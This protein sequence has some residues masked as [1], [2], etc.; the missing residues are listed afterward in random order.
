[1]GAFLYRLELEDG[2][3]ADPPTLRTAV[4]TWRRGDTIPLGGKTLRATAV[5]QGNDPAH[6]VLPAV[7]RVASLLKRWLL[8]THH[9]GIGS[10]HVEAY[11]D[12]S[13]SASTGGSRTR[14]ACS[15]TGCSR[16]P[17]S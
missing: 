4:P 17:S 12:D 15:S 14:A 5:S 3:P 2:T 6:V 16:T 1:M 10:Q 9:G 13:S 8:G 11:L 7:H